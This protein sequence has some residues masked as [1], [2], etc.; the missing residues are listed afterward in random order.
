MSDIYEKPW[1]ELIRLRRLWFFCHLHRMYASVALEEANRKVP[2]PKRGKR[3][4]G[5]K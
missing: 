2:E 4:L 5:P 3:Q 1:S